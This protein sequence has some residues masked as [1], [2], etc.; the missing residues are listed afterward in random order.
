MIILPHQ[1]SHTINDSSN[2]NYLQYSY[3]TIL[4]YLPPFIYLYRRVKTCGGCSVLFHLSIYFEGNWLTWAAQ[5]WIEQEDLAHM[6][7]Q[8]VSFFVRPA[9]PIPFH[10]FVMTSIYYSLFL[11]TSTWFWL[12]LHRRRQS[13]CLGV[14]KP[15]QRHPFKGI[16]IPRACASCC[17]QMGEDR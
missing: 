3:G 10:V 2:W 5:Y 13:A 17:K 11:F 6:R 14:A 16:Y 8:H 1:S 9:P 7:D 12:V 15:T 4:D